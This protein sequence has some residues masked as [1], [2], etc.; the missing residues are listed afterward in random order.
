MQ[1]ISPQKS[2]LYVFNVEQYIFPIVKI[3]LAQLKPTPKPE[4]KYNFSS[5]LTIF[6]NVFE[7]VQGIEAPHWFP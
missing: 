5:A 7:I 3:A 1:V 4:N 6:C 2:Y